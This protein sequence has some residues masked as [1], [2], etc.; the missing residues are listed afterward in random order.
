VPA[1]QAVAAKVDVPVDYIGFT[2]E[3]KFVVGY[4]LD[5]AEQYRNLPYIAC[6][7]PRVRGSCWN[8]R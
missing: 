6:W 7:T 4:G 5:Y 3:D 2:I 8:G 1:E